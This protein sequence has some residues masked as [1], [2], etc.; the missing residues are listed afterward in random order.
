MRFHPGCGIESSKRNASSWTYA[1]LADSHG[2]IVRRN[3]RGPEYLFRV[4]S[5]VKLRLEI[6]IQGKPHS[7]REWGST[8]AYLWKSASNSSA[9]GLSDRSVIFLPAFPSAMAS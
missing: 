7:G 3:T 8:A 6:V 2:E 1:V 4:G 9:S 5:N